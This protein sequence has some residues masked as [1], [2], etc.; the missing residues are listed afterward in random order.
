MEP[1]YRSITRIEEL[2][3][4]RRYAA[5]VV[6]RLGKWVSGDKGHTSRREEVTAPR[7]L[8]SFPSGP[9]TAV[10]SSRRDPASDPRR[11]EGNR[12]GARTTAGPSSGAPNNGEEKDMTQ[13]TPPD[14]VAIARDLEDKADGLRRLAGVNTVG[15]RATLVA[16][17]ALE[18]ELPVETVSMIL[19]AYDDLRRTPWTKDEFAQ[20]HADVV[21]DSRLTVRGAR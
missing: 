7:F 10:T 18:H 16:V 6:A 13:N 9:A 1:S 8:L 15:Q 17:C 4:R 2:T 19:G 12:P 20:V 21:A 3:T 14:A 5:G 11:P